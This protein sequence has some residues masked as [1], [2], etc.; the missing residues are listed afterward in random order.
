VYGL[1]QANVVLDRKILAALA[2]D[3]PTAFAAVAEL[4]KQR[5]AA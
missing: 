1:G 3:D 4:A 2:I 5:R